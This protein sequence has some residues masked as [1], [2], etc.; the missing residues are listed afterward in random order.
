M[1][2]RRAATARGMVVAMDV[3]A[4]IFELYGLKPVE[5]TAAR[6]AYVAR[7]RREKDN[8]AAAAIGRLRKPRLAVWAANLLARTHPDQAEA[9]LRLGTELRRAH[10]E[11]DGAQLRAL[12]HEQHRVIGTLRRETVQLAAGAGEPLR[13]TVMWEIEQLFRWV[14]ADEDAALQWAA[15]R[16]VKAPTGAVGFD[17][18]EPAPGAAP[19]PAAP[20]SH[21]SSAAPPPDAPAPRRTDA[22]AAQAAD[23]HEDQ[24]AR[25]AAEKRRARLAAAREQ[26]DASEELRRAEERLAEAAAA[27][28]RAEGDAAA[29]RDELTTLRQR[30]EEAQ[31]AAR[32]A[33]RLHRQAGQERAKALRAVESAA[34]RLEELD[35]GED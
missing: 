8:D 9:L 33:K 19:P 13:E 35:R 27:R 5:F 18:L 14:L 3:D 32:E 34:R 15:G 7:A 17:G 24:V 12:T 23:D 1:A 20:A 25:R 6:D 31:R 30:V 21:R 4:V 2:G 11:L 16:M 26:A 10:R 29:L 22:A 28:D